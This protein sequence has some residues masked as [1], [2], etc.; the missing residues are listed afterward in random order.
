MSVQ[1][2]KTIK[3]HLRQQQGAKE[4]DIRDCKFPSQLL[5]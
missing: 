2:I 1:E 4:S 5:R 3:L